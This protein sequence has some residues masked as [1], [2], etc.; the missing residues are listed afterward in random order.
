MLRFE[1]TLIENCEEINNPA[2]T[3]WEAKDRA[4][5]ACLG[6]SVIWRRDN[7]FGSYQ[8]S[9]STPNGGYYVIQVVNGQGQKLEPAWSDFVDAEQACGGVSS[10]C[11]TNFYGALKSKGSYTPGYCQCAYTGAKPYGLDNLN[12][13][14][15]GGGSKKGLKR[16]ELR[17]L[18]DLESRQ[19]SPRER[20]RGVETIKKSPR[21]GGL[22][23]HVARRAESLN[24]YCPD[25]TIAPTTSASPTTAPPTPPP[26]LKTKGTK[27]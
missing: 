21:E 4:Y 13:F 14:V 22:A 3:N 27:L 11:T 18:D 17:G 12:P 20:I 15:N 19:M 24:D 5:R 7:W 10:T 26:K 9:T 25:Y 1:Q 16:R 23:D 2:Y 8:N 6:G